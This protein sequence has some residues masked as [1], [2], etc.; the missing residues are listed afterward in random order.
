MILVK[1]RI[2]DEL[3][4]QIVDSAKAVVGWNINF[5]D[6]QGRVM[7][8]TDSSRIGAY[9]KAGHV[10]ARTGQ[11]QTVQAD[12][13]DEGVSKG[14]NYP[15]VMGRQVLGVIGITGEPAVV[16]QYGFLLTKICEVFLKEYR[17]SQEAFSEEEHRSRQVMALIYHDEDTIQQLAEDQPELAGSQYAAAIFRW[18][19]GFRQA[20]AFRQQMA[21]DC[22]GLG[23]TL[24]T[25]IY[26]NT[27]V[28]LVPGQVYPDWERKLSRWKEW[29]YPGILAG[30][31]TE[32]PFHRIHESYRFAKMALQ[33]AADRQ[34][35]CIHADEMKLAF[36]LQSLDG[37]VR[38]RYRKDICQHL[39]D[40]E[41]HLLQVYY[42]QNLSIQETARIL[43]IHK[44][45]LQ[46]RLKRIGE[47]T[48]LDPRVF[49]DAVTLYIA[50]LPWF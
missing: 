12:R 47:A 4:Q 37:P 45:T 19:E 30:I 24:Y 40:H 27:F 11:V 26:P 25:Y 33:A 38:R 3:A 13:P 8:S 6:C 16:G 15:I 20:G 14:V 17:L 28:V 23:M 50:T 29:F 49:R 10:A 46:Y 32:E 43:C 31:G 42:Q 34:V 22:Q 9:H 41:I 1:V 36:L 21:D 48:G 18:H 7:A 2:T 35:F 39:T 44:N 5:I